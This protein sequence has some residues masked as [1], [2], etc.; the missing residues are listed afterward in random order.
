ML[1]TVSSLHGWGKLPVLLRLC[2]LYEKLT[3]QLSTHSALHH[4]A[5]A[6]ATAHMMQPRRHTEMSLGP[7]VGGYASLLLEGREKAGLL[8]WAA[9]SGMKSMRP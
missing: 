9:L 4:H 6:K 7:G 3:K 1:E 2:V 5:I 8:N